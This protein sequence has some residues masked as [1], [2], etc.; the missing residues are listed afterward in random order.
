MFLAAGDTDMLVFARF[1]H[2]SASIPLVTDFNI[3]IKR[4]GLR[5]LC[6]RPRL[7]SSGSTNSDNDMMGDEVAKSVMTF[8]QQIIG[9]C[10]ME[11]NGRVKQ[12]DMSM[13]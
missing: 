2:A 5:F 4:V 13:L 8:K 6:C 11:V 7:R 1:R 9:L 10:H 12:D 3:Q